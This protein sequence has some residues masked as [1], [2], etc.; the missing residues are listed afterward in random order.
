[1]VS[2][3]LSMCISFGHNLA[4]SRVII[5]TNMFEIKHLSLMPKALCGLDISSPKLNGTYTLSITDIR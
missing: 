2:V 3:A 5:G 1:M 4:I